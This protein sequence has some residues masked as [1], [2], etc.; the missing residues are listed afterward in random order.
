MDMLTIPQRQTLAGFVGAAEGEQGI[1]IDE[2]ETGT[3]VV[4]RTAHS[5][6]HLIILSRTERTV[7]V[8]GGA[9]PEVTPVVLQG[10]TIG[11]NLVRT[12]WI[13][14][15]LRLELTDRESRVV[16]SRVRSIDLIHNS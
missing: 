14:I 4:V 1:S 6:Y 10:A 15:G 8:S 16:T 7:L 9:F 13:G 3:T 2:I 11:G 12:G 5:T